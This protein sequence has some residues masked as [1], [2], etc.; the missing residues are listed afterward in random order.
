MAQE[1]LPHKAAQAQKPP[2]ASGRKIA[3]IGLGAGVGAGGVLAI[4][5]A[6]HDR[7]AM[8][9]GRFMDKDTIIGRQ[10][11]FGAHNAGTDIGTAHHSANQHMPVRDMLEE[12]PVRA[13]ELDVHLNED[14]EYVVNHSGQT[15]PTSDPP[16][17]K[18]VLKDINGWTAENPDEVVFIDIN[19]PPDMPEEQRQ[20]G[21]KLVADTIGNDVY[22]G[23]TDP[24]EMT[25]AEI[26]AGGDSIVLMEPNDHLPFDPSEVLDFQQGIL[27]T[28]NPDHYAFSNAAPGE[29]AYGIYGER[30]VYEPNLDDQ[31]SLYA[32]DPDRFTIYGNSAA[33]IPGR[34]SSTMFIMG[35]S[36]RSEDPGFQST[37]GL[38]WSRGVGE[39]RTPVGH[40]AGGLHPDVNTNR[41]DTFYVDARFSRPDS[42]GIVWMDDI[43]RND[44][45]FY[46]PED[47]HK[48]ALNPD[49]DAF[50]GYVNVPDDKTATACALG[51][52]AGFAAAGGA[53]AAYGF[54]K[55]HDKNAFYA[56]E[57][58]DPARIKRNI[59][60][61]TPA[62][63]PNLKAGHITAE[64][65]KKALQKKSDRNFNKNN[66][67][68]GMTN[69][70]GGTN[71]L[72][73]GAMQFPVVGKWL[74]GA[75]VGAAAIGAGASLFFNRRHKQQAR[76]NLET[77]FGNG[78][79]NRVFIAQQVERLNNEQSALPQERGGRERNF[80]N[81][82]I[83]GLSV[84][85]MV[86]RISASAKYALPVVSTAAGAVASGVAFITAG[87][88]ATM[89]YMARKRRYK[90]PAA[91][92][93][94]FLDETVDKRTGFFGLFGKSVFDKF[95]E[96]K[97]KNDPNF[98]NYLNNAYQSERSAFGETS[99]ETLITPGEKTAAI[100]EK[101]ETTPGLLKNL[102]AQTAQDE[103]DKEYKKYTAKGKSLSKP[104][105][106]KRQVLRSVA[107][108]VR[109]SG[110]SNTATVS[111][112]V[113]GL[114]LFFP[115]LLAIAAVGAVIGGVV[116]E[117]VRGKE[118]E[119]IGKKLTATIDK[120]GDQNR[121]TEL[122]ASE[123][124]LAGFIK[125]EHEK[126]R[127]QQAPAYNG[128]RGYGNNG[129]PEVQTN[130]NSAQ[131]Q[132]QQP[133]ERSRGY[134]EEREAQTG[135]EAQTT[136]Y[137]GRGYGC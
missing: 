88:S 67:I 35:P 47:R 17:L 31:L 85:G 56:Q 43:S 11:V 109:I 39:D 3:A 4:A 30:V 117:V 59:A 106:L 64:N 52:G 27:Y 6:A 99:A 133:A 32:A 123:N 77:F 79:E 28:E 14:G 83:L 15:S 113:A 8:D 93:S 80:L 134:W 115:P 41:I 76:E 81:G 95:L 68:G 102:R 122:S 12:T 42:G 26:R 62:D 22:R 127:P 54:K 72:L 126:T 128:H 10:T 107:R 23:K 130:N 24:L 70:L 94:A 89:N 61:L 78:D 98:V 125:N 87:I 46:A 21:D 119:H 73:S 131:Y 84:L 103:L 137:Q 108:D 124:T 5:S 1:T 16:L 129:A 44:P 50:H 121:R 97:I 2:A 69:T 53:L 40:I 49:I 25:P 91:G 82:T 13:I 19:Y 18:D 58:A 33:G 7:P 112:G 101:L 71:T 29:P 114:S 118:K 100:K 36:F 116:T 57:A 55:Q 86:S 9:A 34:S 37:D 60:A 110:Y 75:A 96:E 111:G 38:F 45:R 74:S 132:P 92:M 105:F 48:L 136:G 63:L 135:Y 120:I 104:E 65:V 66:L 51:A 90:D 20:E